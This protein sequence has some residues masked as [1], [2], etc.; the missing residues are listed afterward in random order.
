MGRHWL[1]FFIAWAAT[2]LMAAP[3][4]GPSFSG[5]REWYGGRQPRS[6]AFANVNG[7][8][9]PDLIVASDD[10]NRLPVGGLVV[11]LGDG[12]RTWRVD[13]GL[14]PDDIIPAFAPLD[15]DG[16][17]DDDV[18]YLTISTRDEPGSI[19][20]VILKNDHGELREVAVIRPTYS[21][22]SRGAL[23]AGDFNGDGLGDFAYGSLGLELYVSRGDGTFAQTTLLGNEV[24]DL[25]ASD[26]DADGRVELLASRDTGNDTGELR[27]Y[28]GH[29]EKGAGDP[30]IVPL[31]RRPGEVTV[32]DVDGDRKLDAIV[33]H[34][35]RTTADIILRAGSAEAALMRPGVLLDVTGEIHPAAADLDGDG[36][37]DLVFHDW[38]FG[39]R[40]LYGTADARFVSGDSFYVP[41]MASTGEI[42][43]DSVDT[44]DVDLDG[45][46]DVAVVTES[47]FAVLKNDGTGHFDSARFVGDILAVGDFNKDGSDDVIDNTGVRLADAHGWMPA[48]APNDVFASFYYWAAAADMNNDGNLDVVSYNGRFSSARIDVRLGDGRG[49]LGPA[50]PGLT[51]GSNFSDAAVADVN[52]DSNLDVIV[53]DHFSSSVRLGDGK[54]GLLA[55]TNLASVGGEF[56]AGDLDG[57]GDVDLAGD[58]DSIAFNDGSGKSGVP[59]RISGAYWDYVEIADMNGDGRPDLVGITE[60]GFLGAAA[61]V[62]LNRGGGKFEPLGAVNAG[63]TSLN[64]FQVRDLDRDGHLDLLV[65]EGGTT[66]AEGWMAILYGTGGG[67]LAPRVLS[68]SVAGEAILT[69]DFNGDGILDISDSGFVRFG[70]CELPRRRAARH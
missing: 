57:D 36:F 22:S 67:A 58:N 29:A 54:G 3:C 46:V 43:P 33:N 40:V 31:T 48:V 45:D 61:N 23:V 50:G 70:K 35:A 4:P 2:S 25:A 15:F 26:L 14:V 7:D 8:A 60:G 24:R 9:Y 21:W 42:G 64:G 53:S 5:A 68:R 17:G 66:A 19:G 41:R 30:R 11:L 6:L 59:Q 20:L 13:A 37:E 52:G 47:G 69:G 27:I 65:S 16:D 12:G 55:A 38:I 39:M 18:A 44:A 28:P 49:G 32:A 51:F 63:V 56:A 34:T 62:Y 10:Y 1:M